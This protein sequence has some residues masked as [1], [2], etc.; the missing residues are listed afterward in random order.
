LKRLKA[1]R[2]EGKSQQKQ[3]ANIPKS[4]GFTQTKP[5]KI[6]FFPCRFEN[7]DRSGTWAFDVP[8]ETVISA[9]ILR[10]TEQLNKSRVPTAFYSVYSSEKA[11]KITDDFVKAQQIN[12]IWKRKNSFS[13]DYI[14]ND[15]IIYKTGKELGV[16]IVFIFKTAVLDSYGSL[17]EDV[18][19]YLFD[20]NTQKK[21]H[22]SFTNNF[23]DGQSN[24]YGISNDTAK[25]IAKYINDCIEGKIE[26]K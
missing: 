26:Q 17:Q 16:D 21:Y 24:T 1:E 20:I 19:I 11:E 25:V 3:L 4:S 23:S 8:G 5:R 13:D 7:R 18:D 2:E 9:S 6:A 14:T 10:L 12:D 15:S 22:S